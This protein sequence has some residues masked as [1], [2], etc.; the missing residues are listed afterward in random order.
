MAIERLWIM[1][2]GEA[3]QGSPDAARRLTSRGEADVQR[4]AAWLA[5]EL[6]D[7]ECQAL[8][9][10]ASPFIRA[11]QS[12]A[13]VAE[14]LGGELD[15]LDCITPDDAPMA[16]IDWLQANAGQPLLLVSHM[17]LVGELTACLSEGPRARG[18]G[19]ATAAVASLEAEVWAAGCAT[20]R[21]LTAP[22]ELR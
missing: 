5:D 7:A 3:A 22:G 2:H 17:P 9:I 16:V 13:L 8:R 6:S 1:R 4:M 10:V 18:L 20:L 19:F 14:T 21:G 15:T 12:A 11:Q